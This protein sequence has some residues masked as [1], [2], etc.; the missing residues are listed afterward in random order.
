MGGNEQ[1]QQKWNWTK[2]NG[3]IYHILTLF[4]HSPGSWQQHLEGSSGEQFPAC[5]DPCGTLPGGKWGVT[6]LRKWALE[7]WISVLGQVQRFLETSQKFTIYVLHETKG[8]EIFF[9][10]N[11][12]L[13]FPGIEWACAILSVSLPFGPN[14]QPLKTCFYRRLTHHQP[15]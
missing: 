7:R 15:H 8:S 5:I 6:Y 10:F 14:L 4:G 12:D 9:A 2:K 11:F 3:T 13:F 1:K